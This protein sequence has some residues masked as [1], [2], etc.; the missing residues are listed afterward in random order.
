MTKPE[1]SPKTTPEKAKTTPEKAS[2]T[3]P[4][5]APK[6]AP[7]KV[8]ETAPKTAPTTKPKTAP[9]TKAKAAPKT[10]PDLAPEVAPERAQPDS[11]PAR[12]DR[13]LVIGLIAGSA[14]LVG[15][16]VLLV[17]T[18]LLPRLLGAG[19]TA[20]LPDVVDIGSAPTATWTF[21]W[22]GDADAEFLD[23]APMIAPVGDDLALVWASFDSYRFADSQ[24]DSAGW[25]E[26]YDEQYADGFAAGLE[27][28]VDYERWFDDTT[29]AMPLPRD[30]DYYPEGAYGDFEEWLGFDDGF[31]DA[32]LGE[33]EGFSQKQ[34]PVDPAYSPTITLLDVASGRA[35][36]TVD[37][38]EVIDNVDFSSSFYAID[39]PGSDVIAVSAS[40]TEDDEDASYSIVTLAKSDGTLVSEFDSS[41]VVSMVAFDGDVIVASGE[42]GG[43]DTTVARY[44]ATELDGT[45]NWEQRGPESS[46]GVTITPLGSEFLQVLGDNE[47]AVLLGSSGNEADFGDDVDFAVEYAY[48]GDRL[49]RIDR[50]DDATRIEGWTT[51]GSSNWSDAVEADLARVVDDMVVIAEADGDSF[52]ALTALDPSNGTPR[53]S[54]PWDG[55]FDGVYGVRNGSLLL[56]SGS[57]LIVLDAATGVARFSQKLG[58]VSAL[59]EGSDGYYVATAEALTAY[60]YD[61]KGQRWSIA[62]EEGQSV[63]S[64]GRSLGLIDADAGTLRGLEG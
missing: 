53:W 56:A 28:E 11:A 43:D 54:E 14:V 49:V 38:S 23:D 41:G 25:Y 59:Y 40:H 36:W 63:I 47:G 13:R 7:E 29:F 24:G 1:K 9:T 57:R 17:V 20:A 44:E 3:K 2:T 64:I 22:V 62:L 31:W 51:A 58:D 61:V 10:A 33:P 8:P 50:S 48:A 6:K 30:E 19:G 21:D 18:L 5:S 60:D 55:E 45:P 16:V 42:A 39:V 35:R 26:G 4:K 52:A 32:R 15:G 37:L 12:N 27:Y 34:E 46:F